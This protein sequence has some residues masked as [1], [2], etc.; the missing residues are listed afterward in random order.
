[1]SG[2]YFCAKFLLLFHSLCGLT[3]SKTRWHLKKDVCVVSQVKGHTA[4]SCRKSMREKIKNKIIH[5]K[6]KNYKAPTK[7]DA[8]KW[9]NAAWDSITATVIRQGH[10]SPGKRLKKWNFDQN[11]DF[12]PFV[13]TTLRTCYKWFGNVLRHFRAFIRASKVI[14]VKIG[15]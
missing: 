10:P 6:S 11:P 4:E 13:F 5:Q 7:A 9:A 1:M 2:R 14:Q 3:N 15:F 8:I 12:C